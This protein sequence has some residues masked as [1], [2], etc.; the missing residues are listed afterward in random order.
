M[1]I[2]FLDHNKITSNFELSAFI[3]SSD[4]RKSFTFAS[5]LPSK[6]CKKNKPTKYPI[7]EPV[8]YCHK[9]NIVGHNIM[10]P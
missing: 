7:K 3:L 6:D 2:D 10:L 8:H 5:A 4:W 9:L 1:D